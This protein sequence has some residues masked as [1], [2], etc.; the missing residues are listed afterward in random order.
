MNPT[1]V[2]IDI[3]KNV[4]QMHYIDMYTGE[5]VNKSIK[6]AAFLA[7]FANKE[8]CFIGMEAC[9]GSQ[10][11]ARALTC[12]GHQV[13]LMAPK[14]VKAFNIGNKNDA[15]DARAIWLA[16][17]QPGK[18]VAVKTEA[19]QAVLA[20][21]RLR[22]QLVKFRTMR[23]NCIRGLLGEY[24]EVM[25]QRRAAFDA[26]MPVALERLSERIPAVL[27]DT[28][29]EQ[30][31]EVS[32]LDEQ[33][34]RIEGRMQQWL[35]HDESAQAV[36]A[37]PG[38]GLLTATAAVATIGDA[39]AFKSGREFAAWVGLVPRHVGSGGRTTLLG[40]SKRGDVYLRTLLVHCAWSLYVHAKT[41]S[42][43]TEQLVRRRPLNVAIVAMANKLART[44]WAVLAHGKPYRPD[45]VSIKP[46]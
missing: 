24:G 1:P 34:A 2:G 17:Q 4:F 8:P 7:H 43:W 35:N 30:W 40:I 26:G 16:L 28:F 23:T 45:F 19:Q 13:R 15:A 29:R 36:A 3:A 41:R 6:R 42:A 21:H 14:F 11:W 20:L 10:H 27:I 38:V 33:I 9:G 39:K 31:A 44:I 32:K 18:S 22:Q 46:A 12:M 37:I 5:V 25:P